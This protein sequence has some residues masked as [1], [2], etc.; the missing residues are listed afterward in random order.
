MIDVIHERVYP[1][2]MSG[3]SAAGIR[4]I[5]VVAV[6]TACVV[7]PMPPAPAPPVIEWAGVPTEVRV[8]QTVTYVLPDGGTLEV[9]PAGVRTVTPA[10]WSGD[11]VIIGSDADGMF[12]ATFMRQDGLPDTCYVENELG[13]DRGTH[14]ETRGILWSKSPA[15]QAAEAIVPDTQYL[16]GTRL[17]FDRS[18][19]IT[20]TVAP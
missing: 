17:C 13:V 10:G 18:G 15:F 8:E 20:S 7:E 16:A 14:V 12:V 9:G 2:R 4:P 6:L 5:L 19:H 11:L 3:R 1:R